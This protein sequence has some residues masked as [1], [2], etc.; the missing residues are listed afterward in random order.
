MYAPDEKE[1]AALIIRAV[2]HHQKLVDALQQMVKEFSP[3]DLDE[4]II[5][6]RPVIA[7]RQLLASLNA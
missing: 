7:A 3:N 4:E 5:S 6:H 1:N 2:N